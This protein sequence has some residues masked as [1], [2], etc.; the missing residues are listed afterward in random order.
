MLQGVVEVPGNKFH[1]AKV[2]GSKLATVLLELLLQEQIRPKTA[3]I[4]KC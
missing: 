2:P 4:C 1:G 3:V